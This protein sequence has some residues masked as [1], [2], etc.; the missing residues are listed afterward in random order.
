MHLN[1]NPSIAEVQIKI[2]DKDDIYGG[3]W[4]IGDYGWNLTL[5]FNTY[6]EWIHFTKA[7]EI[8]KQGINNYLENKQSDIKSYLID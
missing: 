6:E 1:L 2:H 7:I 3:A 5:D 4:R 8:A